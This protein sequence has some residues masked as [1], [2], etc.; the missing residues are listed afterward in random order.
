MTGV[1]LDERKHAMDALAGNTLGAKP[2]ETVICLVKYYRD[3]G[4][5]KSD[6]AN[7]IL[8]F[9]QGVDRRI[10]IRMWEPVVDRDIK[11]YW[12]KPT[13]ILS[14]IPITQKEIDIVKTLPSL[15]YRRLMFSMICF[16]K[17]ADMAEGVRYGWINRKFSQV[18]QLGNVHIC[19]KEQCDMLYNLKERGLLSFPKK[20]GNLNTKVECLD[21]D[22]E[23]VMR[24]TEL[25]DVGL[26]YDFIEDPSKFRQCEV[27]GRNILKNGKA[28]RVKYCPQCAKKANSERWHDR[29]MVSKTQSFSVT[30]M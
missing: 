3:E 22:G 6:A 4:Y 28:S 9:I 21:Y 16:A 15:R 18:F 2:R 26:Q 12:N 11:K 10:N 14:D 20:V 27:C 25:A 1:I 8:D 19:V 5:K 7:T 17:F 23:P 30:N 24:V 13:T 29:Y